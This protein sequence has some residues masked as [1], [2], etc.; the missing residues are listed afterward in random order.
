MIIID[1]TD[2]IAGRLATFAAKKA[3]LGNQVRIIN[4][5]KAV[6]SG[7]KENTLQDYLDRMARG[8]PRKGP[9]VHRSPERILRR[10]VRGMIDYKKPRGKDAYQRVLCYVGVPRE[11]EGKKTAI[12]EGASK[13][14]LPNLKYITIYDISKRLGAK[15]E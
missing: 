1:A 11:F 9:F 3:I 14:K 4:S 6:I 5:E 15:L 10:V 2:L 12:I 8:I 13:S 7:K